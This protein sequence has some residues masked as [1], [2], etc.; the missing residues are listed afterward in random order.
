MRENGASERSLLLANA[1]FHV[2]TNTPVMQPALES[3]RHRNMQRFGRGGACADHGLAW[4]RVS[5]HSS[6]T[7][8]VID[9]KAA[10]GAIVA[11]Q[12]H[13]DRS[14]RVIADARALGVRHLRS[15]RGFRQHN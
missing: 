13:D 14:A 4:S 2:G 1:G 9:R 5:L 12:P 8:G 10:V 15:F 3:S 6:W 11:V 7:I